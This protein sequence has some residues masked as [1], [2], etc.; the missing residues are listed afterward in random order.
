ME[1]LE[2]WFA[3]CMV[4]VVGVWLYSR[5]LH[6]EVKEIEKDI[7]MVMDKIMFMRIEKHDDKVFAYNAMTEEFICQGHDMD[8][9]NANFG[10]RYPGRR[11]VIVEPNKE[12]TSVL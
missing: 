4:L 6:G 7:R 9:L 12:T 11:G 10:K 5:K 2:I 1:S 3:L 8:D